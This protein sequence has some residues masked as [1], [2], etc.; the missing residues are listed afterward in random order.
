MSVN[1]FHKFILDQFTF[2]SYK[3]TFQTHGGAQEPDWVGDHKRRLQAYRV[4]DHYYRNAGR[5]WLNTTNEDDKEDRR[6]YGDPALIVNTVVSSIV[7]EGGLTV[8]VVGAENRP[9]P[10]QTQ[11]ADGSAP[12]PIDQ[13]GDQAGPIGLPTLETT[14][15]PV[16]EEQQPVDMTGPELQLEKLR[17]WWI[18]E[19][20]ALKIIENERTAAKLG[21][22]VIVLGWSDKKQRPVMNMY[23]PGFYFPVYEADGSDAEGFTEEFPSRV[24]IAYEFEDKEVNSMDPARRK[25]RRITW[26]LA[27]Y[28]DDRMLE[29]PWEQGGSPVTC[30][31][32]DGVWDTGFTDPAHYDDLDESKATWRVRDLDLGIDF[33]PVIHMPN[34]PAENDIWGVSSISSVMQILDD[35]ASTDTD[36]AKASRIT[37]SPPLAFKGGMVGSQAIT[38]Y[39]PGTAYSTENGVDMVDTSNSLKALIEHDK[40]MLE[41][42]SVNARIPESMLGRIKPNEVPSGIALWLSFAPHSAMIKEMRLVREEKYNLMLKMVARFYMLNGDLGE[43]HRAYVKFGSF[44]PA[45]KKE[46]MDLV[47]AALNSSV[48]PISLATAV[49]MLQDAGIPIEDVQEELLRIQSMDFGGASEL[50]M[51]TGVPQ[52]ARDY[53]GLGAPTDLLGIDPA[54]LGGQGMPGQDEEGDESPFGPGVTFPGLG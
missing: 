40:L 30:W 23:D 29:V 50:A 24:H 53:L 10:Q 43:L 25:I 13:E 8:H 15:G 52:D 48:K 17:D 1:Q 42:L 31:M 27:P 28:E 46:V 39:G 22:S 37:G 51:A 11:P 2:L 21:D 33:I 19:R 34:F 45:D 7:G 5:E 16:P 47:V 44:L 26:Q 49:K 6:E 36:L 20:V 18:K 9:K 54:L 14:G 12:T 4:L 35:L 32:S 3:K 38:T 41:R